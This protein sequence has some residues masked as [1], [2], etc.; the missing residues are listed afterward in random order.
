MVVTDDHARL[1]RRQLIKAGAGL[2]LV[3]GGALAG[4]E[5]FS[6]GAPQRVLKA[7]VSGGTT[8]VPTFRSRPDLKPPAVSVTG[9]TNSPGHVLIDPSWG[10]GSEVGPLIVDNEGQ[11]VWF[12][13]LGRTSLATN[14]RVQ[15][16]QHRNVLTWWEGRETN[17][18]GQGEGVIVGNSYDELMRVKAAAGRQVDLHEFVLTPEGTALFTCFPQAVKADLSSIGGPSGGT[19]WESI[20]QEVDLRS[21]RL[22]L[23]WRSLDHIPILD[24]Y[25]PAYDPYD[26]LHLNSINVTDDGNLLVSG[27]G[28]WSV[29]KLDRRTGAIIWRL[30][31]K[32]SDFQMENG[33]QFAYQHHAAPV[34][35]DTISVFDNGSDGT[36][37]P[38]DRSRA[39]LVK[40]DEARRTARLGR[41][42]LHPHPF[43][44][45]AMGS[46]Q[47]L[48]SGRVFVGWGNA[49]YFTEYA[50]DGTL[51]AD[52]KLLASG[53]HSYRAFR[54][55]WH[56]QPD[57]PP[58]VSLGR[59]PIT[60]L[61]TVYVSWNGATEARHWE[62][63]AGARPHTLAVVG[64]ARRRGFETAIPLSRA[65]GYVAVRG[66]D[67][68]G[69]RLATSR[70]V[71]L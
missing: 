53:A 18:Y 38:G 65:G 29:Y 66:L 19:V 62:V 13:P 11:P 63:L 9:R 15:T 36:N 22:L 1:T 41:A 37:S 27:R 2:A 30:G 54:S 23:E 28:T 40:L 59:D 7:S 42:Y 43:L 24:S 21:G 6:R 45:G 12:K 44:A 3:G 20:F 50:A 39:I 52:A 14:L 10:N 55:A 69:A 56:G 31:G 68:A 17:Y 25:E 64:V 49:P 5:V 4:S 57:D 51:L 8:P 32:R 46:V 61:G 70:V 34:D 33:A 67:A 16:Y 47:V 60:G 71:K 58:D 26:Y 48:D 35:D